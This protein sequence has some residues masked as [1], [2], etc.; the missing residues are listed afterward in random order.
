MN[1]EQA[2]EEEAKAKNE[3]FDQMME[4]WETSAALGPPPDG[5]RDACRKVSVAKSKRKRIEAVGP[6]EF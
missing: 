6:T 2:V 1:F 5:L 3:A 4:W